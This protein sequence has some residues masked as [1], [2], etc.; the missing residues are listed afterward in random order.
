MGRPRLEHE[1]GRVD[2]RRIDRRYDNDE[3]ARAVAVYVA[4]DRNPEPRVRYAQFAGDVAERVGADEGE[5]GVAVVR[6]AIGVDRRKVDQVDVLEIGDRVDARAVRFV[7]AREQETVVAGAAAQRIGAEAAAQEIVARPAEQLVVAVA[8]AEAVH[9][10]AA[11]Q[12]VGAVAAMDDEPA[13]A[14]RRAVEDEVLARQQAPGDH[15][16]GRARGDRGVGG[17]QGV[18]DLGAAVEDQPLDPAELVGPQRQVVGAVEG[19]RVLAGAALDRIA[20]GQRRAEKEEVVAV[21]AARDV[22]AAVHHRERVRCAGAGD[23]VVAGVAEIDVESGAG[24]AGHHHVHIRR[25][26]AGDRVDEAVI[27][28]AVDRARRG[29]DEHVERPVGIVG[30]AS[31]GVDGEQG[32]GAQRDR[33][34]HR[35]RRSVDRGHL[36]RRAVRVGVVAAAIVGE[37]VAG[38]H[39]VLERR[40]SVVL[41]HRRVGRVGDLDRRDRR[42]RRAAVAVG[43]GEADGA[44]GAARAVGDV[45]IADRAHQRLD[46]GGIGQGIEGDDQGRVGIEAAPEGPDLLRA[47]RVHLAVE[48]PEI[49]E[50]L[51][52]GDADL[53]DIDPLVDDADLVALGTAGDELDGQRAAAEIGRIRVGNGR[54]RRDRG[55]RRI[56]GI[57]DRGRGAGTG[58]VQVD[59]RG[60][61]AAGQADRDL[62]ADGPGKGFPR[63]GIAPLNACG[64]GGRHAPLLWAQTDTV[65]RPSPELLQGRRTAGTLALPE[66]LLAQLQVVEMEIA[67][68]AGD[69]DA[70]AGTHGYRRFAAH[71]ADLDLHPAVGDDHR[72]GEFLAQAGLSQRLR[73]DLV[74]DGGAQHDVQ[75][76]L[77]RGSENLEPGV[78]LSVGALDHDVADRD[79]A[80]VHGKLVGGDAA[81][82]A[83]GGAGLGLLQLGVAAGSGVAIVAHRRGA[84]GTGHGGGRR[85]GEHQVPCRRHNHSPLIPTA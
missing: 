73:L 64:P 48:T 17:R 6:I 76:C 4:L 27:G 32:A 36:E 1:V 69:P 14:L 74:A 37:E 11:D 15:G 45:E 79:P 9:P 47:D 19:E 85:Q 12:D 28:E 55:E 70:R 83:V 42:D 84:G 72:E 44:V 71:R 67:G 63:H 26:A 2:R 54:A 61:V 7:G 53:A 75:R 81:R 5:G 51:R 46:H 59:D 40:D 21:E 50:H 34:A 68:R 52:F 3:V 8:A 49:V 80:L 23:A 60:S 29:I 66:I 82:N 39:L 24:R 31:V 10:L 57:G 77:A 78:I 65:R 43:Q 16:Q 22:V 20:Q 58:A 38:Q 62:V 56:L 30:E 13:V 18:V 25:V 41:R 33:A 35:G